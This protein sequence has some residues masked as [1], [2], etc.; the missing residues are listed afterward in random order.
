MNE[1][2]AGRMKSCPS[3]CNQYL[4]WAFIEAANLVAAKQKLW[5][6]NRVVELYQRIKR[7]AGNTR[8]PR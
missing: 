5:S 8:S 2:G 4:Q 7:R 3:D 1:T 6:G